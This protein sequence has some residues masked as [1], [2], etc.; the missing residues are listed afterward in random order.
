MLWRKR[1]LHPVDQ[2]LLDRLQNGPSTSRVTGDETS[3][4]EAFQRPVNFG[5]TNGKVGPHLRY[6]WMGTT[7]GQE[8]GK[9]QDILGTQTRL[10]HSLF[11]NRE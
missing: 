10:S 2:E 6:G 9:H 3:L 5:G 4:L 8:L 11:A 7:V 1:V